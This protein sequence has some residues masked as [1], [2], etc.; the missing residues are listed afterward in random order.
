MTS[1]KS[2]RHEARSLYD[3]LYCQRG[4]M[5]NRIKECQLNLFADRTSAATMRANQLRLWFASMAYVLIWALRRIALA[6]TQFA[7][8]TCGTIGLKLLKIGGQVRTS[9]RRVKLAMA[10]CHPNQAD[11]ALA[12]PPINHRRRVSGSIVPSLHQ[13][14]S[15]DP[16]NPHRPPTATSTRPRL[17]C[18]QHDPSQRTRDR[19][20]EKSRLGLRNSHQRPKSIKTQARVD[21]YPYQ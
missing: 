17:K 11:F 2:A 1:L 21:A 7:R 16:E 13:H 15:T 6:H 3:D 8:A 18:S 4:N 12:H 14:R 9:V 19:V 10:S 20:G 5:E